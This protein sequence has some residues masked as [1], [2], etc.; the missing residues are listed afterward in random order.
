MTAPTVL[1][2]SHSWWDF[3]DCYGDKAFLADA[4][5]TDAMRETCAFCPVREECLTDAMALERGERRS[6]RH[7]L[8]GGLT[9]SERFR[10][11]AGKCET[12]G[13][14]TDPSSSVC[15]ACSPRG[16]QSNEHR[17]VPLWKRTCIGCGLVRRPSFTLPD[18]CGTCQCRGRA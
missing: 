3:A 9:P 12:C 4:P 5:T 14:A 7:G 11:V 6:D 16:R 2:E 1:G 17:S 8:R 10:L 15:P 13:T 18:F